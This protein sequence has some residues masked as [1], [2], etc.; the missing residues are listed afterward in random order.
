MTAQVEHQAVQLEQ[1]LFTIAEVEQMVAAGIL[2]EDERVELIEGVIRNM[3]PIGFRHAG[4]IDRLN[5][6]FGQLGLPGIII[7]VQS[8][9]QLNEHSAPQPDLALPRFRTD[10]YT[11]GHPGP[12]DVL[13]VIEVAETSL[14]YDRD[15][16]MPS[17]ARAMIP[18][19][20]LLNVIGKTIER[21]T[22]S[23]G[24]TYRSLTRFKRGQEIPVDAV[25]GLRL[26]TT[27]LLG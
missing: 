5:A 13:L 4:Y 9:I 15:V 14:A 22:D 11:T 23:D 21:Y 3:S 25:P 27:A 16:K 7:R 12:E 17:Y 10:F 20:W 18:E 1:R 8:P 24:T 6:L 2:R 26:S 19:A